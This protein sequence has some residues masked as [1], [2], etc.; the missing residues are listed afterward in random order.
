ME[1]YI[2]REEIKTM[3]KIGEKK[4]VGDVETLAS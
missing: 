2:Y 4:N 1:D 3:S